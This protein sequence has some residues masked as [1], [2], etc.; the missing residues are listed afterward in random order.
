MNKT[1]QKS[2]VARGKSRKLR[3]V[4]STA[5]RSQGPTAR[6]RR[7]ATPTAPRETEEALRAR[8]AELERANAELRL[9]EN[10]MRALAENS[11]DFIVRLD[12]NARQVYANRATARLY[13]MRPEDVAGKSLRE[14]GFPEGIWRPAEQTCEQVF[15]TRREAFLEQVH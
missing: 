11:E 9:R 7:R 6:A 4:A 13:G 10:A 14:L 5:D 3:S 8:L 1:R 2:T 12:R 15:T